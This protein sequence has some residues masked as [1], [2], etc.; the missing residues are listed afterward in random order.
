MTTTVP[1]ITTPTSLVASEGGAES[2]KTTE[3]AIAARTTPKLCRGAVKRSISGR[4]SGL[5]RRLGPLAV[6]GADAGTH[7]GRGGAQRTAIA[8]T[9]RALRSTSESLSPPGPSSTTKAVP[10]RSFCQRVAVPGSRWPRH[11]SRGSRA[12]SA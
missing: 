3:V 5:L 4:S 7:P 12:I 6:I 8:L 10:S 1:W 2:W 11:R 9:A